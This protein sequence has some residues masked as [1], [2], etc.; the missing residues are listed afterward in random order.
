MADLVAKLGELLANGRRCGFVV[1]NDAANE[2]LGTLT[3]VLEQY[4]RRAGAA[5]I[6]CGARAQQSS[7]GR[8]RSRLA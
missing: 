7:S 3:D 6:R 5:L 2:T 8:L 4:R 1:L